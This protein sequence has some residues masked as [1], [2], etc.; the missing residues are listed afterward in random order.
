M[1]F[2]DRKSAGHQLAA[3]LKGRP[4]HNPLVLAIP[5]GGVVT[6]AVI[7]QE[8]GADLDVVLSRRLRVSERPELAIGAVSEDGSTY[9]NDHTRKLVDVPE[10]FLDE[11]RRYQLNE[12]ARCKALFRN[13]RPQAPVAGRSVIVADDGIATGSTMIAA[14]RVVRPRNP[15]QLIV[16]V[17]VA[18]PD[19]LEEVRRLCDDV[20]CLHTPENFW[21]IGDFYTDFRLVTEEH[22]I[23]LFR[24]GLAAV[25]PAGAGA[26]I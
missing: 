24:A 21:A 8:L 6:G 13:I 4:L 2:Q 5:G 25:E 22:A 12:I 19:R 7:A 16:A 18:P 3:R 10:S 9:L 15:Y 14:L 26:N 11:E 23:E 1:F 20:V 17:P